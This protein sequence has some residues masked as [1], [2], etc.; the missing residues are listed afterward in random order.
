MC[1]EAVMRLVCFPHEAVIKDI[2]ATRCGIL[3]G[4]YTAALI[5]LLV[6][7][8]QSPVQF[9]HLTLCTHSPPGSRVVSTDGR[10]YHHPFKDLQ[11]KVL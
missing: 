11:K 6:W 3:K 2:F 7:P 8:L 4:C 9:E 5:L 1:F 10:A